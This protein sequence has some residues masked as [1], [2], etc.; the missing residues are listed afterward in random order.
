M[1]EYDIT[2][3]GA[4][5]FTGKLT[6]EQLA[7]KRMKEDFSLAL[8]GRNKGKLYSLKFELEKKYPGSEISIVIADV[9]EEP[10]IR[11]MA[12][13]SKVLISTVGPYI[14]YG[15]PVVKACVIY[16][17]HYLDIT[18]EGA[19]VDHIER[20]YHQQA[21][22][23]EAKIISCC[24]YDSIPADMGVYFTN[25]L[26]PQNEKKEIECFISVDTKDLSSLFSSVSGGTWHTA[27]DFIMNKRELERQSISYNRINYASHPRNV[28]AL[29][30][31]FRYREDSNTFGIPMPVVDI[32]IVLRSALNLTEYGSDFSY[33]HFL[34]IQG[35]PKFITGLLG[36]G[37]FFGIAQIPY[38]KDILYSLKSSGEGPEEEIR[39]T[40]S[41]CHSFVGK[42]KSKTVMTTVRGGDPGY[43]DTSKIL[44]E[45][46]ICILND[47]LPERYGVITPAYAMGDSLLT[48]LSENAGIEFRVIH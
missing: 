18:G 25:K 6:A 15:E 12:E 39:N 43:G 35:L 13:S 20:K 16:G 42:T 21:I 5:G 44:A 30:F 40:N 31:E 24:G 23:T 7:S 2:L 8:S 19:F 1:R 14:Q 34:S 9:E 48:R 4:T 27:L 3:F 11:K 22:Q 46:A 26:L 32:E 47:T 28:S 45:S 38:I 36:I 37:T 10:S 33:G 41:F 29:P 17:T